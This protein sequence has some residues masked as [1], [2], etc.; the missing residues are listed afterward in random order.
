MYSFQCFLLGDAFCKVKSVVWEIE[1]KY[2][3]SNIK[4]P[5][6]QNMKWTEDVYREHRRMDGEERSLVFYFIFVLELFS[7]YF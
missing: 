7:L 6:R 5:N 1:G 3:K 4:F 2:F